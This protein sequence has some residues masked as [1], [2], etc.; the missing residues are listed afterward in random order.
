[1]EKFDIKYSLKNI[2]I[3]SKSA[4]MKSLI[5]KAENL[6]RRMR[7]KAFFFNKKTETDEVKTY[8]FKTDNCPPQ[9]PSLMNFERD[10]ADMIR[11]IQ[12]KPAKFQNPFQKQMKND[13]AK[14]QKSDKLLIPADKTRNIYAM[15]PDE[16]S[17]LLMEN[18]TKDYKKADPTLIVDVNNKAK[19][20]ADTIGLSNRIE[21]TKPREA[22]ITLKDHKDNFLNN[23][24][25]RLINPTKSE[26]GKISS[27]HLADVSKLIRRQLEFNQWINSGNVIEWF[28]K[29]SCKKDAS[30]IKFD[31]VDFYPS[32]SD[33]L[34]QNALS[35][36]Q[37]FTVID[38]DTIDIIMYA[39]KSF[40]TGMASRG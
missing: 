2:P 14:I 10:V 30:F 16:Y 17:K 40:Y 32:I 25:C 7:W 21:V 3:S 11:N 5:G 4:Y 29:I 19:A 31:I 13:I 27:H 33:K 20:I 9:D 15:A 6:I 28:K 35:F 37:E 24:K 8:G 34:L 36:A 1:M 23:P 22:Y 12:F 18:V 39:K 26:I 38:N